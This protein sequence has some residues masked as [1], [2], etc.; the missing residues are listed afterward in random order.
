MNV[1]GR[2]RYGDRGGVWLENEGKLGVKR[3]CKI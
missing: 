1:R 3:R 2:K